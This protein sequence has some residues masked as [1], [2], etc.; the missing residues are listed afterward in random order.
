MELLIVDDSWAMR[1]FVGKQALAAGV[2]VSRMLEASDGAEALALLEAN[3]VNLVIT[4]INMPNMNGFELAQKI[5]A[6]PRLAGT[7]VIFVSS[8]PRTQF[9]SELRSLGAIGY[10]EKPFTPKKLLGELDRLMNLASV[11]N[12]ARRGS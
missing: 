3:T 2:P 7:P 8:D 12:S 10:I 4:D 5:A 11:L 9:E 1:K 6:D